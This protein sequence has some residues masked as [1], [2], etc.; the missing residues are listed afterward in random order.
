[1][2]IDEYEAIRLIDHEGMT[3][4]ECAKKMNVARTTVQNIYVVARKKIAESL[5]NSKTLHIEGGEYEL[6][7]GKCD[8][9]GCNRNSR[10]ISNGIRGEIMKIAIP[11]DA[12]NMQ[13]TVSPSLGRATFFLIYDTDAQTGEFIQNSA[14]SSS[15]GAG[16]KAAQIIVDNK[17]AAVLTPRCGENAAEVLKAANVKL[18]KTTESLLSA[19]LSLFAEGKLTELCEINAGLNHG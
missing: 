12:N 16:I 15:S 1:M 5:V 18:Y 17:A 9:S 11:V 7:D 10:A 3:Q 8:G 19:N 2:T 4:E 14:S 6:C 13:T